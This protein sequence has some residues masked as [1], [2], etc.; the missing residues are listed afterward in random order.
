[1]SAMGLKPIPGGGLRVL[2]VRNPY[3]STLQDFI[4]STSCNSCCLRFF[5]RSALA[6]AGPCK[7]L[8]QEVEDADRPRR[9]P[10]EQAKDRDKLLSK[11]EKTRRR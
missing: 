11:K 9:K 10:I 1:M 8:M 3:K 7:D 5:A 6:L 4:M 2:Q